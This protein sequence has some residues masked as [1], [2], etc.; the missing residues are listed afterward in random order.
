[1]SSDAGGAGKVLVV[2]DDEQCL[3]MT[4]RVLRHAGYAVVTR[5]DVIGTSF[6]VASERPDMVLFDLNMPLINGDRLVP[7]VQRSLVNPPFIVLYS[8]VDEKV[9]EKRAA[10]CGANGFIPK[11]LGPTEFLERVA[12]WFSRASE[13]RALRDR[14]VG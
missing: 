3:K 11:G 7:L 9:L 4:A 14:I 6:A 10:D 12:H 1:M 8:G 2:D 5:S 13:A